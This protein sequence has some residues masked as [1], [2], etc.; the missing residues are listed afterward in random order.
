[1]FV[2][3]FSYDKEP[4]EFGAKKG[5]EEGQFAIAKEVM[6]DRLPTKVIEH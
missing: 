6:K 4:I 5:R 3:V 2:E 1:V